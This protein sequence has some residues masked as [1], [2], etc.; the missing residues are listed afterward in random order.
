MSEPEE[1]G[2]LPYPHE[3][4]DC[5]ACRERDADVELVEDPA[6]PAHV[7]PTLLCQGC[8]GKI[9]ALR[10]LHGAGADLSAASTFTLTVAPGRL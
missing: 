3:R 9:L 10:V 4:N 5:V 7:Q 1:V 8:L 2:K 6:S